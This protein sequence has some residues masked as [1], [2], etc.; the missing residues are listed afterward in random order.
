MEYLYQDGDSY[1]FMDKENYEQ[2]SLPADFL[3]G[4]AGLPPAQHRRADSTSTNGRP[5]GIDIPPSVVL[6]VVDTEPGIK[7]ATATNTFKRRRWRPGSRF[8]CRL[9]QQGREDQGRYQ[10]RHIHGACVALV[11]RVV[12]SF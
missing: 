5:I 6:T 2:L 9:H 11:T 4:Q 3:E 12:K 8:R 10:R 7:N 1:I